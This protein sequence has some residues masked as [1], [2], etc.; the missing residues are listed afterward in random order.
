MPRP[1]RSDVHVDHMLTNISVAYLQSQTNFLADQVFPNIPVDQQSNRYFKFDKDDFMRNDAQERAVSTASAGSGYTIDNT[2]S[3]YARVYGI[4]KDID[5]QIRAN[6]DLPLN[7][8]RD[9]T[10]FVTQQL[11]IK[12]DLI[13]IANYFA[14]VW[15]FGAAGGAKGGTG[16]FTYWDDPTN[17]NPLQDVEDARMD[18]AAA[19]GFEPN[20]LVLGPRVFS[21]LKRH[22]LVLDRIKYTQRGIVTTDILS[23]LFEVDRVLVPMAVRNTAAEG[24]TATVDFMYGNNALLLYANPTPSL[25]TPSAGY[26]FSWTGYLGAGAAGMRIRTMRIDE[27]N[28]DRVEGEMAFDMKLVCD[29]LGYFFDGAIEGPSS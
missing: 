24:Q 21:A 9:A 7:M 13:W 5:D 26:T 20:T 15:N 19:T 23:S 11:L 27:I 2:P 12:R 22:P 8:D 25:M 6:A 17:S 14:D 28:S 29:D 3:Y 1:T 16:D 10:Q 4:H 18:M